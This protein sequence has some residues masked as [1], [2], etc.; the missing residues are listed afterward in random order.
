VAAA[1]ILERT[2]DGALIKRLATDPSIF[3]HITDDHFPDPETWQPLMLDYV[4]NLVA[5]DLAGAFGFG[6]F[7]PRTMTCFDSHIGFLPR[8][9]GEQAL[10]AFRR[11]LDWIWNHTSAERCVGEISSENRRAISFARRA[12]FEI[13]GINRRSLKRGGRLL[14]QVCLG[15]S[16]S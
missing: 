3:P 6:I 7:V 2:D 9:Y 4:Y 10:T 15:I 5:I 16:R 14:D 8:S 1:L 13:F 12:G 11:M